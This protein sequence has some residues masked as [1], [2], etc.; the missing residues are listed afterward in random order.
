MKRKPILKT[1]ALVFALLLGTM[2]QAIWAAPAPL[3]K[4][5]RYPVR[6]D[7]NDGSG[8]AYFDVVFPDM[9]PRFDV[10]ADT[11]YS[12]YCIDP[13]SPGVGDTVRYL[14]SSYDPRLPEAVKTYRGPDR[15]L[16]QGQLFAEPQVGVTRSTCR[17]RWKC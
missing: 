7:F 2:A 9:E 17:P 1:L 13:N 12:G 4:L 14:Y 10:K 5:P 3:L 8:N 16:G 6:A 11:A 15:A